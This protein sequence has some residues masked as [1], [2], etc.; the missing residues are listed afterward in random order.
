MGIE[1]VVSF[2][3]SGSCRAREECEQEGEGEIVS[4]ESKSQ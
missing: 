2:K 4:A 3:K 1:D